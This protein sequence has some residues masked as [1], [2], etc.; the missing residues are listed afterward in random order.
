MRA[1]AAAVPVFS[2]F[3]TFDTTNIVHA[4]FKTPE[5]RTQQKVVNATG[6]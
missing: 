4:Y 2:L 5:G 3:P 1:A 6:N